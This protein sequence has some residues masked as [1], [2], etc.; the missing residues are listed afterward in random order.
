M[1]GPSENETLFGT[2]IPGL[3]SLCTVDVPPN[4][5]P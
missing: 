3:L 2:T 4:L 5:Q 1:A